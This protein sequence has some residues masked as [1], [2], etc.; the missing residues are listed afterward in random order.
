MLFCRARPCRA[1]GLF[2]L[3]DNA[4][5][6]L[7]IQIQGEGHSPMSDKNC[8]KS[9]RREQRPL[10]TRR[11]F[12][13]TG[14]HTLA[15]VALSS[16][17]LALAGCGPPPPT[18]SRTTPR[19]L[20]DLHL[21]VGINDWNKLTPLGVR[22]PAIANLAESTFNLSGTNWKDSYDAGVDLVCA[23][24]FNVFDE[25]L[26]MPTDPDPEAPNHT[27]AML[28]RF[29]R[30]IAGKY[31]QY[32]E[33]ATSPARLRELTRPD[34]KKTDADWKVP[35]IHTIEGG[36][37]LGGDIEAIGTFAKRGVAMIGLTHFFNKGIAS[38]ANSYPFFPD[39]GAAWPKRGLSGYGRVVIEEIERHGIIVD[40]I[41]A[42]STALEEIFAATTR[43]MVAS[44]SSVRTLGDHPY[45]LVD[46]HIEEIARRQ[47]LIGVILDPY[48]LSNYATAR[49]AEKHGNLR[50]V[51]RTIRHIV[52]LV[53]HEHVG[54]GSDFGGFIG[55]PNDMNRTS[56][57]GRLRSMLLTEFGDQ[58]TVDDILANNVINFI[59]SNWQSRV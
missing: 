43:P 54:I 44:H 23:T 48:L 13:K 16:P 14:S 5:P 15:G 26:S 9:I 12:L 11:Q 24:H 45:S 46:E 17:M 38:A 49:G 52:K 6:C 2:L 37:A 21:H 19:V 8:S 35:V 58:K 25:W 29:E 10:I 42:T 59:R 1:T 31:Q 57:I 36:H 18:T 22:Y 53:G 41:H 47:G 3:T 33:M 20:A 30:Q 4:D 27:I 32:A 51:V 7:L 34:R 50:D 55:P 40:V 28:D 56:Q 39:A